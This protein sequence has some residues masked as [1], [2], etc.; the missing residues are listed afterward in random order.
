MDAGEQKKSKAGWLI[1]A[2]PINFNESRTNM[3]WPTHKYKCNQR[4]NTRECNQGNMVEEV[5]S[6]AMIE[7][8]PVMSR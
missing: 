8:R 6:Q 7:L 2:P 3:I 1:E 4:T 5:Q